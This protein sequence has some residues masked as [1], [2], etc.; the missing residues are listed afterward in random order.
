MDHHDPKT[1]PSTRELV[2]SKACLTVAV[3]G[4]SASWLRAD[5]IQEGNDK[6]DKLLPAIA[7][8]W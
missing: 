4:V 2:G 8:Q 7:P 1:S 6:G 3:F 5:S